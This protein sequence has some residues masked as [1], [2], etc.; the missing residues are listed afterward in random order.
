MQLGFVFFEIGLSYIWECETGPSGDVLFK[1][2]TA[3]R[4]E[5][6]GAYIR[7]DMGKSVSCNFSDSE[8]SFG[9]RVL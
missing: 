3:G 4:N 7:R 9:V 2:G 1:F 8:W 6:N 5:I